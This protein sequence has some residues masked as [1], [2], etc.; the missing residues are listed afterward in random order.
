MDCISIKLYRDAFHQPAFIAMTQLNVF[1]FI[2]MNYKEL[3]EF[4]M[5]WF[6]TL[7]FDL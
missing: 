5:L 6:E 1:E 4:Y 2:L 7:V 3:N